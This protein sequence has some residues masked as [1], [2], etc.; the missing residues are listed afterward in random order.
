[1][2][3]VVCFVGWAG[4]G[5]DAACDFLKKEFKYHKINMGSYME[6][7]LRLEGIRPTHENKSKYAKKFLK[8]YGSRYIID[9]A[10]ADMKKYDL[11]A[12]SGVRRPMEVRAIKKVFPFAV[13]VCVFASQKVRA[14]RRES[15][16]AKIRARDLH[17]NKVLG[18]G[19]V[20]KGA[21]YKIDNNGSKSEYFKNIRELMQ[22][23][24]FSS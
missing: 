9:S 14:K 6:A 18:L 11:V 23:L 13:F 16:V 8:K 3:K 17:D 1:M 21:D 15:S 12:V 5:K 10:L 2:K 4:S 22:K 20:L 7:K 19:R 24:N